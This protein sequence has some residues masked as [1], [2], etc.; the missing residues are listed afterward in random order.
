MT[1]FNNHTLALSLLCFTALS[2]C[3]LGPDYQRPDTSAQL[4]ANFKA[5]DG[6]KIATPSDNAAK[7]EW[8]KSFRDTKL[9]NLVGRAMENNQSL[10]AA[11]LRVDQARTIADAGRG[12]LLPDISTAPSANRER[13]SANTSRNFSG[14]SGQT[15][16]NL[17]L[18]LVLDYEIDLWGK[19][20]R[21]LQA[22]RAESEASE[23]DYNNVILALQA[24]LA[25]NYFSL[26]SIDRE[27]EILNEAL[28][29][30]QTSLTLNKKRFDAGDLD[31]VDVARAETEVSATQSEIFGLRKSRAELENAIAVLV[32]S[33]SSDFHISSSPLTAAPPNVGGTLP[34]S[35]LERR[36]DVALAERIMQAENERIGVAKAAFF[37]SVRLNGSAGLE[38]ASFDKLFRASSRT[39]GIGPEISAPIFDG[40]KNKANLKRSQF[41][42]EETVA[43]YRQTVLNAVREVDDALAGVNL[44]AKQFEAQQRTATAARRT[45]ELSQ[46]RF[47]G[48]LVAFFDVVDAQ[49]TAFDAERAAARVLGARHLA[50]IA[51][52]KAIGGSWK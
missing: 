47:D 31:E 49:R 16:T 29:L 23:A 43:N 15:T 33:P 34:T 41:R 24:D 18:P 13:R 26:R 17:S 6:W 46:K 4:P 21:Q 8:W 37:P 5:A 19:L 35:L 2:G 20:R 11:F 45:V 50:A 10:K 30:R 52:V 51:L 14:T 3:M 28:T 36:P 39:W 1:V 32:G 44:L 48:G 22:A 27:I 9:N 42:Y 7:G 12:A 40:G 38:S 25:A